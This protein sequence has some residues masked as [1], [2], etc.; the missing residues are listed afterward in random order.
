[1]KIDLNDFF[2]TIL[3]LSR[4]F[5]IDLSV[6][7]KK[8]PTSLV[9]SIGI[10]KANI[11]LI[12]ITHD[13]IFLF[14]VY[15][16]LDKAAKKLKLK[17]FMEVEPYIKQDLLPALMV[18]YTLDAEKDEKRKTIFNPDNFMSLFKERFSEYLEFNLQN[19]IVPIAYF[20]EIMTKSFEK[21]EY[22]KR[23]PNFLKNNKLNI[24]ALDDFKWLDEKVDELADEYFI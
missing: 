23:E 4:G 13:E 21:L 2:N 12:T 22:Y 20:L 3:L 9:N 1:M 6:H 8:P 11:L 15:F 5:G 17:H 7:F 16:L 18:L 24:F 14:T 19:D 10:N